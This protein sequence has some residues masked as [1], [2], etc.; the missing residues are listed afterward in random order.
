M[1]L[2]FN[3]LLLCIA[4]KDCVLCLYKAISKIVNLL[5][6]EFNGA[7]PVRD[8]NVVV[9]FKD[10][11]F[12]LCIVISLAESLTDGN[13]FIPELVMILVVLLLKILGLHVLMLFTELGIHLSCI[14]AKGD[15]SLFFLF[16]DISLDLSE[17]KDER[18]SGTVSAPLDPLFPTCKVTSDLTFEPWALFI[19]VATQSIQ[20][21][22]PLLHKLFIGC[23]IV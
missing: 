8:W 18:L 17:L 9:A 20:Q 22:L 13:V 5:L 7:D 10:L 2:S 4:G 23:R 12:I 3:F 6:L 11:D 15:V 16:L 21:V 1:K 19:W 14:P